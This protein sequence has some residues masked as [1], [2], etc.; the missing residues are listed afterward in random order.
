[1]I[2]FLNIPHDLPCVI[3]LL[4]FL[5]RP[6]SLSLSIYSIS[7]SFLKAQDDDK[8]SKGDRAM[9]Q[10][11]T[12]KERIYHIL[13][14]QI[15]LSVFPVLF[16]FVFVLLCLFFQGRGPLGAKIQLLPLTTFI[17]ILMVFP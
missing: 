1:M 16:Y 3:C 6:P 5:P 10:R 14:P 12:K 15:G 2:I 11:I 7:I 9:S 8:S 4:S 13:A 17:V